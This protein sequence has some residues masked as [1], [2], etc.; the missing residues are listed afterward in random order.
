[1]K[2][3]GTIETNI[4]LI[5]KNRTGIEVALLLDKIRSII[6]TK[7]KERL[8]IDVDNTTGTLVFEFL[9]N[10]NEVQTYNLKN[11]FTISQEQT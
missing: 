3:N 5:S 1:M 9:I 10:E 8:T 6:A 4:K 11:D 2:S 7:G